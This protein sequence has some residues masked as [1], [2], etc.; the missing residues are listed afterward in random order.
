MKKSLLS[1]LLILSLLLCVTC[2]AAEEWVCPDCGQTNTGNFCPN[3]G[4][5]SP[6]W[7]CPTCGQSNTGNF[8]PADGTKKPDGSETGA[9]TDTQPDNGQPVGT[10]QPHH[11]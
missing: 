11:L 8:C 3:C 7:I 1:L 2:A 10:F 5:K 9:K 4:A 6:I